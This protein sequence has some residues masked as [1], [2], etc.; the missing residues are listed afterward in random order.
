[1]D[2]P[3]RRDPAKP[4]SRDAVFNIWKRTAVAAGLP[5]GQRYGWHSV[6]RQFANELR[7][8]SLKDLAHLGGWKNAAT[9]LTCYQHPDE[10]TQRAALEKRRDLAKAAVS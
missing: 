4:L 1:M 9:I 2:L 10:G 5:K 8:V 3:A 6:R 7:D